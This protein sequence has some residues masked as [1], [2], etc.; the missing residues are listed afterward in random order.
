MVSAKKYGGKPSDY[1]EI[2]NF[3]DSTKIAVPDF[4]HRAFLHNAFGI[5]LLEKVFGNTI[6]NSEGKEV[7]VRDLGEDH[8]I[9]DLGFIPT[10]EQCFNSLTK[11]NEV[12]LSGKRQQIKVRKISL[13]EFTTND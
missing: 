3:F 1:Q 5:F 10:L 11:P 9:Q 7:S 13:N 12:W 6:T 2:H 8:V 4:R